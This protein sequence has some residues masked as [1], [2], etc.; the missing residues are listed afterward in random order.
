MRAAATWPPSSPT[1]A[2]ER[3]ITFIECGR[4]P[5]C[6]P[7]RVGAPYLFCVRWAVEKRD[8][9][10]RCELHMARR[11]RGVGRLQSMIPSLE[12]SSR[13]SLQWSWNDSASCGN[14]VPGLQPQHAVDALTD[15]LTWRAGLLMWTSR[16]WGTCRGRDRTRRRR[17]T[18]HRARRTRCGRAG[19][20]HHQHARVSRLSTTNSAE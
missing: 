2:F 12:S 20:V 18:R 10:P 6:L 14:A 7:R 11:I 13:R 8:R 16:N 17:G 5:A 3:A 19:R 1:A 4:S 15:S 9:M